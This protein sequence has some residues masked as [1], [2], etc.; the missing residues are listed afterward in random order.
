MKFKKNFIIMK[1][2]K[3]FIIMKFNKIKFYNNEVRKKC[4][5]VL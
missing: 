5:P 1:F 3:N 2:K 4:I